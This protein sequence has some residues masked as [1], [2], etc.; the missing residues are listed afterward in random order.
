MRIEPAIYRV[1]TF[2][3]PAKSTEVIP[4]KAGIFV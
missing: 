4:A 1:G 2:L 3:N